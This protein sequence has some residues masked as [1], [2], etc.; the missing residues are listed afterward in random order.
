MARIIVSAGHTSMDPGM[1]SGDLREVDLTRKIAN[2]TIPYLRSNGLITLSVPPELDLARRI[3][4]INATGYRETL[5][6]I[7][8]EIHINDGGKSGLEGWYKE[9][10]NNKS[11]QLAQT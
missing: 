5:N 3:E 8:V 10:G 4:W 2:A 11:Q 1:S 9:E 6:D 7:A